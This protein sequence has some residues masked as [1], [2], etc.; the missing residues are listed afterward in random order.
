MPK[1]VKPWQTEIVGGNV[2]LTVRYEN[3]LIEFEKGKNAIELSSK[4]ELEPTLQNIKKAVEN[5]ACDRL[6]KL[7]ILQVFHHANQLEKNYENWT[8]RILA[9]LDFKD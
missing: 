6:L 4:A 8:T 7:S 9:T 5:G 3:K 1:R 2:L